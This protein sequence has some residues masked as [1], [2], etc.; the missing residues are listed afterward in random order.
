M[1]DPAKSSFSSLMRLTCV[2]VPPSF[3]V[4]ASLTGAIDRWKCVVAGCIT[5]AWSLAMACLMRKTSRDELSEPC[6]RGF[7]AAL[8]QHA[9]ILAL[10]AL[11]LDGGL[12]LYFCVLASIHYWMAAGVVVARRPA[13]PTG[14]DVSVVRTGYFVL[15]LA[16]V[17]IALTRISVR[18]Y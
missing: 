6:R 10:A 4:Y 9:V 14:F 7:R 15:A 11:V 5:I 12:T 3:I 16:T 13:T 18:G 8:I 2:L 17:S 1:E